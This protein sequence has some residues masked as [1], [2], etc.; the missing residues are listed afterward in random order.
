MEQFKI[1]SPKELLGMLQKVDSTIIMS[2]IPLLGIVT[3]ASLKNTYGFMV[4]ID[5]ETGKFSVKVSN[6]NIFVPNEES[7]PMPFPDFMDWFS[8]GVER[9]SAIP[10]EGRTGPREKLTPFQEIEL[11]EEPEFE[12]S[13]QVQDIIEGRIANVIEI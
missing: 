9:W 8:Q 13:K 11:N 2:T 3:Y 5:A 12:V 10:V 4:G 6:Q 1:P 7:E